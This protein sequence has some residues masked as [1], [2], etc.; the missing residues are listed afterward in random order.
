MRL[1]GA[2][3]LHIFEVSNALQ[4]QGHK[5][6][7]FTPNWEINRDTDFEVVNI[8]VPKLLRSVFYQ[9]KVLSMI[10]RIKKDRPDFIYI[11]AASFLFAPGIISKLIGVPLVAE[12]NGIV[13]EE[14]MKSPSTLDRY[15]AKIGLVKAVQKYILKRASSII[16]VTDGLKK[17]LI[18]TYNL[19]PKTISVIEN[20][21]NTSTVFPIENNNSRPTVGFV[22]GVYSWQ[23]LRYAIDAIRIVRE[24]IPDVHLVIVGDGPDLQALR[25]YANNAG[26]S[27]IVDF[28]GSV[29][30]SEVTK[31]INSFDVCLA[32]YTNDRSGVVSPFKMY[33][34]LACGG[35]VIASDIDGFSQ[36]NDY[37]ELVKPEDEKALAS[38]IVKILHLDKEMIKSKSI[39]ARKFIVNNH[40]WEKV[41]SDINGVLQKTSS[42]CV[43]PSTTAAT[44]SKPTKPRHSRIIAVAS[45]LLIFNIGNYTDYTI[46]KVLSEILL[47]VFLGYGILRLITNRQNI[48]LAV[49]PTIMLS[50]G[51]SIVYLYLVGI[52]YNLIVINYSFNAGLL[53]NIITNL[54]MAIGLNYSFSHN[55]SYL[56]KKI[57]NNWTLL[58]YVFAMVLISIAGVNQ[59]NNGGDSSLAIASVVMAFILLIFFAIKIKKTSDSILAFVLFAVLLVAYLGSWLR[60]YQVTGVDINRELGIFNFIANTGWWSPAMYSDA[61]NGCLSITVLPQMIQNVLNTDAVFLF[62]FGIPILGVLVAPTI[63]YIYRHINFSK[64]IAFAATSLYISQ[65]IIF[66]GLMIP[67]RQQVALFLFSLFILLMVSNLN[68]KTITRNIIMIIIG[69]SIVASHYSTS[70]IFIILIALAAISRL[71]FRKH[72][73]TQAKSING[74]IVVILALFVVFWYG[75]INTGLNRAIDYSNKATGGVASPITTKTN[76]QKTLYQNITTLIL[77]DSSQ[78]NTLED[79]SSYL[80]DKY[81]LINPGLYVATPKESKIYATE[82]SS[83]NIYKPVKSIAYLITL[84]TPFFAVIGAL[85]IWRK[86]DNKFDAY[87]HLALPS[88]L[89][90]AIITV[91]PYISE[92]YDLNRLNQQFLIITSPLIIVGTIYIFHKIKIRTAII[93]LIIFCYICLLFVINSGI[94]SQ[95]SGGGQLLMRY[96]N[97]GLDYARY[98]TA[99]SDSIGSQWLG[100]NIPTNKSL[101]ADIYT[102][103]RALSYANP[104][105]SQK[106]NT[107]LLAMTKSKDSLIFAGSTNINQGVAISPYNSVSMV[108]EYPF[109]EI[110]STR[111]TIYS[112][113]GV[114]IYE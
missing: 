62:K 54:L 52:I 85:Y 113:G 64:I 102:I 48:R 8:A 15:L 42:V 65:S 89:I 13:H 67:V 99:T 61:Y 1:T 18:N 45:I 43:R 24:Q 23:G 96:N 88:V 7:L 32:Y 29:D 72:D 12:V 105:M 82:S 112:N 56:K 71:L 104:A 74:Y 38:S 26:V 47:L 103:H 37:I 35:Q 108:Y 110:E 91:L 36:F 3:S 14:M 33:E 59:L 10:W 41:A 53:I 27:D 20:G 11:R 77:G 55:L 17:Y 4:K 69:L 107:D 81:K 76:N 86:K 114:N 66:N 16:V 95:L 2:E 84:T 79:Y 28:R 51:M 97:S 6:K 5:V 44:T 68:L 25:G 106:I 58:L 63:Y 39:L 111:N 75:F 98:Y 30:H 94:L 46:L 22:G 73:T 92:A 9:L 60:G 57:L 100:K 90:L 109:V 87:R 40:S 31:V 70:Y 49:L 34:Y 78:K 101:S 19:Q 83:I 80:S 21:V 50:A 93:N